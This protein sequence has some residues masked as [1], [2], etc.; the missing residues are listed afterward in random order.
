VV[1]DEVD[2][3][4][5]RNGCSQLHPEAHLASSG[6]ELEND[7]IAKLHPS[8]STDFWLGGEDFEEEGN[9]VW[10][11]GTPFTFTN[12]LTDSHG[13]QGSGGPAQNCLAVTTSSND[14]Y[15]GMV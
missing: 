2:W 9:W 10:T 13:T 7:F 8:S 5:V 4:E 3:V 11:D 14:Y 12:W 6:S 1:F 15:T